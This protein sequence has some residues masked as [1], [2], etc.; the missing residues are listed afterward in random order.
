MYFHGEAD[1]ARGGP[2]HHAGAALSEHVHTAVRFGEFDVDSLGTRE[3]LMLAA[4]EIFSRRDYHSTKLEEI[5]ERAKLAKGTIYLY[6][7][8]K[9]DL[10]VSA[11]EF[12]DAK[13]QD[14]IRLN[15]VGINSPMMRFRVAIQ[16]WLTAYTEYSS[17]VV[18]ATHMMA[19][20]PDDY[21]A[22]MI[23]LRKTHHDFVH[24]LLSAIAERV[25]KGTLKRSLDLLAEVILDAMM[26]YISRPDG[27]EFRKE[28]TPEKYARCLVDVVLPHHAWLKETI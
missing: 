25:G 15:L 9:T 5:A 20:L 13:F 4:A 28:N 10:I 3:R 24:E 7:K 6:F 2:E 18:G 8:D 19:M 1:D 12:F 17:C 26:G 27:E 21:K 22:R 14:Q 11:V 16:L 23:N